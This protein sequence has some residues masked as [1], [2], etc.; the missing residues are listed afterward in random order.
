MTARSSVPFDPD[1]VRPWWIGSGTR[2]ALLLH[3]FAGT[4]PELRRL[5][6]HLAEH[7]W[8]CHGPVMA[9]HGTTPEALERT[10]WADWADSAQ[11]ALD[12]LAAECEDVVV[13]GQSMGGAMAL[14]LAAQDPRIRAV[15][16][17]AAPIWLADWRLRFIAGI[18][19]VRRWHVPDADDVDL[20]WRDAR[21]ELYSYG[22]RSTRS[23]HELT[24]FLATV[25]GDLAMVRQPV[26]V[27]QGG[28]DR[29]VDPRNAED[30]ARRLCCS[31]HVERQV[32]PRSG[33]AMSVDVDRDEVNAR[34]LAWCDRF[35]PLS[36]VE[37]RAGA[38]QRTA[39]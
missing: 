9:G 28:R 31:A 7:G 20:Y 32:Y 33:H 2:G 19:H 38:E 34:V 4:P 37:E 1:T 30:L 27:L 15:A 18:K 5:G 10:R 35:V 13:V 25:R 36:E 22:R 8:R 12:A 26:L 39:S 24:R 16:T 11:L 6:E 23:L 17:L 3:G 29:A 21:E 14:H